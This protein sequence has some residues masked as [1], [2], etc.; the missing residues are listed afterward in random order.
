MTQRLRTLAVLP[1]DQGSIPRTQKV[2]PSANRDQKRVLD[3]WN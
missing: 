1:E 2:V 3:P